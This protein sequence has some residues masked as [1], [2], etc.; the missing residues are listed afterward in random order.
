MKNTQILIGLFLLFLL[1]SCSKKVYPDTAEVSII[2]GNNAGTATFV[3]F[4]YGNNKY[5]AEV[6]AFKTA[7]NTMFYNGFPGNDVVQDLRS[8]FFDTMPKSESTFMTNFYKDRKYLTFVTSQQPA[9]NQPKRIKS[10]QLELRGKLCVQKQF[11]LNY[12]A[13]KSFLEDQ[14]QLRKGFSY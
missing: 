1:A 10:K 8:P 12:K 11:T 13:L 3:A 5:E 14:N 2:D 4:G 6:D 7:F 9:V